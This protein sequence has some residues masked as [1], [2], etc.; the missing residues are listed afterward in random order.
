MSPQIGTA[1][2]AFCRRQAPVE[3]QANNNL[4]TVQWK[5]AYK[6]GKQDGQPWFDMQA[7]LSKTQ[8]RALRSLWMSP[9]MLT[10]LRMSA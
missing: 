2:M 4:A 10:T 9:L 5:L 1:R 3:E 7:E 6:Q 8:F